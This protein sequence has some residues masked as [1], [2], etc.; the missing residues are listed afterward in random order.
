VHDGEE[1]SN[2]TRKHSALPQV[3]AEDDESTPNTAAL[4][5]GL[6]MDGNRGQYRVHT[7]QGVLLCGLRGRLRKQLVYAISPNL[8]HKV[9]RTNQAARD[10]VAVGDRVRVLPLDRGKGLIEEVLPRE[11]G[12]FTRADPRM[13]NLTSVAGIDQMV[14]VFAVSEPV[15]HLGLLDRFLVLAEARELPAVIC[16]NKVDLGL[17]ETLA[18]RLDLY[19]SLGYRV[20]AASAASGVG[21][22]ELRGLLGGHTSALLGPS[23]VGKSSLLNALQPGLGLLVGEISQSTGKGRHT[24]TGTQLFPLQGPQG[25]YLADTAGIRALA[26]G[27]AAAGQLDWCFREFRPYLG[28]CFHD[29]CTHRGEPRCAVRE[30]VFS[31][32]LDRQRYDSY[33]HLY[34]DGAATEGKVWKDLVSSRSVVGEGEFR[35]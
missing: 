29:D 5:E 12:A 27:S 23:G 15:P 30:A 28:S 31:D 34:A 25:G 2:L 32:S 17:D 11:A 35:L 33:V 4:I 24:T 9:R 26:L 10:P 21:L 13:G 18:A 16:L 14:V 7:E 20:V 19:R 8:R 6:I 1:S 3:A 22:D